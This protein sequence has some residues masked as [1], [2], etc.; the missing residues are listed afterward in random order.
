V[1]HEFGEHDDGEHVAGDEHEHDAQKAPDGAPAAAIDVAKLTAK[2][3]R[4][5]L[6]DLRLDRARGVR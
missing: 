4:L 6:D 3:Y 1:D 5:M 2:V